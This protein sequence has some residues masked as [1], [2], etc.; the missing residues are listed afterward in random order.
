M[1]MRVNERGKKM[2]TQ[3]NQQR[4]KNVKFDFVN[5]QIERRLT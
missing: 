2:L 3:K 1:E 4:E 5:Q